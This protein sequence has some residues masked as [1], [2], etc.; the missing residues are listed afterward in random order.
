MPVFGP[1]LPSPRLWPGRRWNRTNGRCRGGHF[2]VLD[3]L[4][5]PPFDMPGVGRYHEGRSRFKHL[6]LRGVQVAHED[7]F[8]TALY[9]DL[10]IG[11]MFMSRDTRTGL[12]RQGKSVRPGFIPVPDDRLGRKSH[13][14][15]RLVFDAYPPPGVSVVETLG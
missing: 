2:D 7:K 12:S 10:H 3:R 6:Y 14:V 9:G 5:F 15:K 8:F 11:C 1:S 4:V 13:R